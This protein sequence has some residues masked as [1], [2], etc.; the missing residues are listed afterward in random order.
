MKHEHPKLSVRKQCRLLNLFRSGLYY[1]PVGESSQ[2]LEL[3]KIIDR[4]FLETPWYGSR[5]MMRHLQRQ[6]H[7]CSRHRV[8]RLMRL[9]RLVPIYQMP[10]TSR[11]NPQH[12]IWPY[13]LKDLAITK[14]NQVWCS[15]ITY[16]PMQSGFLYLVVI[17][18]W[19]SR[20]VLSWRLSNTMEATMCLEALQEA[21]ETYGP[22]EIMNTDQGSQFTGLA[23]THMV[24]QAG[25]KISMDGR[26][27]WIDNRMVERLWRSLKY[28][29]V[30][31]RDLSSGLQARRQIGQWITYYNTERPHSTHGILTP[32]EA[33][34]TN[35]VPRKLAA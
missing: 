11:K 32:S 5:Q 34:D 12:K 14:P 24:Q 7:K 3:M 29:C 17:M 25:V 13:L 28:E 4:Q 10:N 9:M 2:T 20:K 35:L 33:Y 31:V 27:R 8:R 21:L 16:I 1:Q 23:W 18:D 19:Y 22:P 30:Y 15:D 26:R 6:G